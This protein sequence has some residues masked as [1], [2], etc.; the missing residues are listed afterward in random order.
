M[1]VGDRFDIRILWLEQSDQVE[2]L[3]GG[4]HSSIGCGVKFWSVGGRD[5][6]C[7]YDDGCKTFVTFSQK[8]R[9]RDGTTL[10]L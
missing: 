2:R 4:L 8:Q 9:L 3:K 1:A 5:E 7:M 6:L 10:G